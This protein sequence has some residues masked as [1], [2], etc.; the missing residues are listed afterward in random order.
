[1]PASPPAIPSG[2]GCRS[3]A[4]SVH[5]PS[6]AAIIVRSIGASWY[7]RAMKPVARA[8]RVTNRAERMRI[9]GT[10]TSVS[11]L[12]GDVAWQ[13]RAQ[14]QEQSC[15]GLIA[16]WVQG[17]R[18]RRS[19]LLSATDPADHLPVPIGCWELELALAGPLSARSVRFAVRS[20]LR[21]VGL[22]PCNRI[23]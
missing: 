3:G 16:R 4:A 5:L 8:V 6:A 11:R 12:N 1:M 10:A 15:P 2:L 21:G 9:A 7:G 18:R 19:L 17:A 20:F 13:F 14:V 22:K 23:V